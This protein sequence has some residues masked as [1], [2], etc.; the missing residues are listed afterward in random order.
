MASAVDPTAVVD[1]ESTWNTLKRRR[2]SNQIPNEID[3]EQTPSKRVRS[4]SVT[5][6]TST[7]DNSN[8]IQSMFSSLN[9]T[10]QQHR[11]LIREYLHLQ[12]FH[13]SNLSQDEQH[14]IQAEEDLIEKVDKNLHDFNH[15]PSTTTTTPP[16]SSRNGKR[17]RYQSINSNNNQSFDRVK[18][19]THILKRIDELKS[20]GKWTNQRLAKCLEPNKR[21]THWDY[22][23]D[24]MRWLAEDFL[25]EK[26]WKQAMAKKISL[27]VQRYFR[28][29]NLAA[30]FQQR[31]QIQLQRRQAQFTTREVM[32]FWRN[33]SKIAEDKETIR[34]EELRKNQFDFQDNSSSSS[35]EDEEATIEREEEHEPDQYTLHE[36]E[37]LQAD[38]EQSLDTVLKRH[39]GI[40][41]SS[42]NFNHL[43][44][45]DD[46][47]R[48]LSDDESISTDSNDLLA[49]IQSF[50]P[51][52]FTLQTSSV[53]IP[54]PFLLRHLL[55]DYQQIALDWL[56]RF[57]ENKLN[58]I[59]A[60]QTG[61]GKTIE[62]IALLAHLAGEKGNWGPHLLVVP[63][64]QILHWEME[65]KKWCPALKIAIAYG[66][67]NQS[68]NISTYHVWITSY[69]FLLHNSKFYQHQR[70]KYLILDE[71]EQLPDFQ[72][73][74]WQT[75]INLHS[76]RRLL[77]TNATMIESQTL[78]QFLKINSE[79]SEDVF[80]YFI[81]RRTET[82]V[83]DQLPQSYEHI[84]RCHLS[85]RQQD[86]Y[87]NLL[88]PHKQGQTISSI[89]QLLQLKQIC[90][91]PDLF[92]SRPV[93]S[94]FVFD[95]Q[96]IRYTIPQLLSDLH[97]KN[98]SFDFYSTVHET[99]LAFRIKYSLQA[100]KEM[101]MSVITRAD[102][103]Q[104]DWEFDQERI[105]L[106]QEIIE[107]YRKSSTW[108]E[109]KSK[110]EG[111][112][113][114]SQLENNDDEHFS[115]CELLCRINADRCQFQ[116]FYGRDML[117]QIQLAMH[118]SSQFHRTT[119]SGYA[120]CQWI[121]Q[122]SVTLPDYFTRTNTLDKLVRVNEDFFD[123][124][125]R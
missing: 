18:H 125:D 89:E 27:A 30:N 107:R 47:S 34:F 60:D 116:S 90:N 106:T 110:S 8:H 12:T 75:L 51:T 122:I 102:D 24:E 62:T 98:P 44:D 9:E 58:C 38:Q 45:D 63:N 69:K 112:R 61:L 5:T 2:S 68:T 33:I 26:R 59:L 56:V 55:R 64:N 35:S 19:E 86:F 3:S 115:R 73:N 80:Q 6:T 39:Y 28:E 76:Q 113:N 85:K 50:Q 120:L 10:V 65:F 21:K 48:S 111:R 103:Q 108:S 101:I 37:E 23:L 77:L 123:E 117:S 83:E 49:I 53:Q 82:D 15:F 7:S 97:L 25:L 124:I 109:E 87:E 40:D 105:Q 14:F 94:P 114:P 79:L 46:D 57:Y 81:L 32:N 70:W 104:N 92:Q 74:L 16:S 93:L 52:G 31:E 119:F 72:S 17:Q 121:D 71:I 22:L 96:S 67:I 4:S 88:S 100:T 43:D 36:L 11:D 20:D 41:R 54:V 42:E 29:K 95:S 66:S 13:C 1:D 118:P 99:F 78:R 84:L 91:H